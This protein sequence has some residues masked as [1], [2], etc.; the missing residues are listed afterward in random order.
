MRPIRRLVLSGVLLSSSICSGAEGVTP[1][2]SR[3]H[4]LSIH[5]RSHAVH[6]SVYALLSEVLQL[7]PTYDPVMYGKRK[8]AAV[9][10]GNLCLE[11]CGPYPEHLYLSTDFE[12]MFYG[13]TFEPYESVLASA[14]ELDRR[15]IRHGTPTQSLR[16]IDRDLSAPNV[17]VGIGE[18]ENREARN[19]RAAKLAVQEG[20]PIG[21]IC[22]EE[23]LIGYSD[24][25]NLKKW[26]DLIT[27]A[28]HE[29]RNVYRLSD[30]LALRFVKHDSKQVLGIAIKVR[31]L[32]R[33][34]AFLKKNALLGRVG[35]NKAELDP[36]KIHGLHIV[37][38]E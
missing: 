3:L 16:I 1:V 35:P 10:A 29:G 5:V 27:P 24:N 8:Y 6:G 18:K 31:S 30:G 28:K 37:L 13:L 32:G 33:A 34:T 23:I 21:L 38:S 2:V 15:G 14:R 12:G 4:T 19:G 22:V 26:I 7:P 36:F 9:Q 11:P 20:G 25:D 17:T